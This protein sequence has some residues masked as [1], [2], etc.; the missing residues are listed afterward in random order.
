VTPSAS[1]VAAT[2]SPSA[3]GAPVKLT[4]PPNSFAN[5]D[6]DFGAYL[7]ISGVKVPLQPGT[8]IFVT[9]TFQGED[10]LEV[11]VPFGTPLSPAPRIT[12]SETAGEA[13]AGGG[14]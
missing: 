6:R 8:N 12:P 3:A 2:P 14:H 1:P 7:T 13:G 11:T 10:P 5:L 4:I 9:F